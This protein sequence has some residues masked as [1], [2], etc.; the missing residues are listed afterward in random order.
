MVQ[1]MN[2]AN[3]LN[4]LLFSSFIYCIS[5]TLVFA[6]SAALLPNAQQAFFDANGNP[7][8]GGSVTFYYPSTSN[9]KPI[10]Q[11]GN[12]VTP[13]T[14]PVTLNAAGRPPGSSGIYGQGA[15][16]QLVKDIN[17]NIIW[18]AV[19]SS[20]A[21]SGSIAATGDGDLVGTVKPWAGFAAPS[22]YQFAY[23]QQVSRTTFAAL[24][25]AITQVSNVVCTNASNTL[26]GISDTTSINIGMPVEAPNCVV[27]GT[28]VSS[29]T[30][31][32]VV[33]SNPSTVNLNTTATF[34]PFGNGDGSTT[35]TLPDFRGN[36]I[37]GRPNMGGTAST[38]LT[39]AFCTN[40]TAQGTI[41]GAQSKTLATNNLPNNQFNP[42]FTGNAITGNL[43]VPGGWPT[44][45]P[46]QFGLV[47]VASGVGASNVMQAGGGSAG[48]TT[49][50]SAT[51]TISTINLNGNVT[52]QAFSLVQPTITLNYIIKVTPDTNSAIATGVTSLGL[53]TG[54]IT[55]GNGLLC[56]GNIIS[57]VGGAGGTAGGANT[58]VQF[59]N[60]ALFGGS[61][62]L[63]WVSPTL[64]IGA[65]ATSGNLSI[66]GSGS[67]N[68]TQTVQA[69]AGTPTIIWG[70]TSGTPAVIATSPL[71]ITTSTGNISC[72]TCGVTGSPLSQ[73]AA[74]TS[75]QFAGVLS[76]ETGTGLAVFNTTPTLVT[77][78]LGIATATTING[79]TLTSSTGTL[80]IVNGKTHTVDN[81]IEL[82]GVDSSVITFQATD[83]YVGRATT[84]T[85]TNKTLDTAGTGNLFK[86]NGTTINAIGGNTAKVGTVAGVL[87][88]G[89]CVSID[90]NLNFV[91]AGGACTTGGGG[92]TVNSG[93]SGQLAY[94]G[95]TGT[96]V[97]GN[98]NFTIA[99]GAV[100]I[101]LAGSVQGTLKLAGV[102]SGTTT[103]AVAAAASGTLTLPSATDTIVARNTTDTLTNKTINTAT[104]PNVIL[105]NT[106]DAGNS[107]KINGTAITSI[108]GNTA[109][110]ASTSGTL[111]NNDCASFDASGNIIDSG[112]ICGGV[113]NLATSGC[114]TGGP[115]TTTGTVTFNPNCIQGYL[116][117]LTISNDATSDITN[118]IAIAAGEAVDSTNV[119]QMILA[120]ALTRKSL[121]AAWVVGST[122]GCRDT[123]A[124]SNGTWFIHEIQ[125][126]DTG[127][128]DVLCSLSPTA[129]TMPTN[130]NRKR[131]I[132]AIIRSAAAIV[133]FTQDGNHFSLNTPVQEIA[134]TDP[135]VTTALTRT[136]TGVPI[137]V[138]VR[139]YFSHG[140]N[141][142][143]SAV[144][145]GVWLT[146]LSVADTAPSS[147]SNN[148]FTLVATASSS[149]VLAFTNAS[150][151]IR[152][153]HSGRDANTLYFLVTQGWDDT[154]G[155]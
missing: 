39:T 35:F 81:S 116:S 6:Q 26:S 129:P 138:R 43:N 70:N 153:R 74:T 106:A 64:T 86:I 41:C 14:N 5:C 105:F 85:L 65:V 2:C 28:T 112:G 151:Q 1:K 17:G 59:N 51:G 36:V 33:M 134:G 97:S 95:S 31:S 122:Q 9:L 16:R 60:S 121:N 21:T 68:V 54:D 99:T 124:I 146:D 49:T 25:T 143:S 73:F 131:R 47:T 12:E 10:W 24:F 27:P 84:D 127:V 53:M 117:G 62:N 125:R 11:D 87:V 136:L 42:T 29:K 110:L 149:Q 103:L 63:T 140:N 144:S 135:G 148:L 58:Q 3:I 83:T 67:G 78:I 52:Q 30:S 113:T 55:C 118:E 75:V 126:S 128:V 32:T 100:T 145:S 79:L 93:T 19:T 147:V 82:A 98:P 45:N 123:G 61:A 4:R 76:D 88:S 77:P 23:G 20:V 7:L 154:R 89:H 94:Y 115:I 111:T 13:Y 90:A 142:A 69:T 152:T 104:G 22:Q 56:T 80:T 44:S 46:A 8:S 137:G 96:V 120:S 71:N 18:D 72:A 139:G 109:K 40:A 114:V 37:A 133:L 141:S 34:F 119:S 102:T 101:G 38:N 66:V 130:Y 155:Q 48:W 150:G 15:Y 50:I 57:V 92:G 107:F 132:G 91:D 108:S